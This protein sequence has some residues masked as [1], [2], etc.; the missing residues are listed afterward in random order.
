[1]DAIRDVAS[2]ALSLRK[3]RALRVRLPLAR[4]TVATAGAAR[5]SRL[6]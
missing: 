6:R 5:L 4:L 2:A 1:M 3:A